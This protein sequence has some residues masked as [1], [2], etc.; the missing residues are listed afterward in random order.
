[1]GASRIRL[2]AAERRPAGTLA[3]SAVASRDVAD[4]AVTP[5]HVHE[6]DVLAAII[7][8]LRKETGTSSRSCI[9][10]L[11]ASAAALRVMRFPRMSAAE[12]RQS[13]RYEA[14]RFAPWESK[15]VESVVRSHWVNRSES[16]VGI[17]IA[18]RSALESRVLCAKR[19]GLRVVAVD[20]EA[21]ALARAFPFADAVLDVGYRRSTLH[22][23]TAAG[24]LA[25]FIPLGGSDI[26]QGI[27]VDLTLDAATAERRKRILGTAGAG[28]SARE[29]FVE[30]T[31]IAVANARDRVAVRRIALVG[32]GARLPGLAAAIE[33][34]AEVMTDVPVSDLLRNGAYPDDV[35]RAAA[36][37][38]TL[39]AALAA[40]QRP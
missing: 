23:F 27:A 13:A 1:M 18:R 31:A 29:R 5:E 8:D 33:A 35:V 34:A 4:R 6:V 9:L 17:G 21:C 12:R 32:N 24:P 30:Q 38:W 20:H 36:P 28:E 25:L 16:L 37:D 40:W 10:A 39:A 7:E 26:T 11:P 19:A 14:E 22:V 2:V 15:N 3:I